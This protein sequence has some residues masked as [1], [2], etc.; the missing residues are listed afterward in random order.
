MSAVDQP[1]Q[2]DER[3][4]EADSN[5]RIHLLTLSAIEMVNEGTH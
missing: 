3:D 1:C 2:K 5:L 4:D